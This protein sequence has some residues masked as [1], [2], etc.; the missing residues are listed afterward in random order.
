MAPVLDRLGNEEVSA[1][2]QRCRHQPQ[3]LLPERHHEPWSPC[4]APRAVEHG[5][6]GQHGHVQVDRFGVAGGPTAGPYFSYM[7]ATPAIVT[8]PFTFARPFYKR[9][10][11]RRTSHAVSWP[12]TSWAVAC[13]AS[14]I[15]PRCSSSAPGWI[16]KRGGRRGCHSTCNVS[17]LLFSFYFSPVLLVLCSCPTQLLPSKM[18]LCTPCPSGFYVTHFANKNP[19]STCASQIE[20]LPMKSR[21]LGFVTSADRFFIAKY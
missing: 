13:C 10:R 1:A 5:H 11:T 7:L 20:L 15:P 14:A 8:P 21:G 2:T 12:R 3:A 9:L 17:P 19:C 18:S 6:A 16:R 4:S